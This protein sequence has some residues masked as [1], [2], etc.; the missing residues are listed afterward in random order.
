MPHQ[1]ADLSVSQLDTD[2]FQTRRQACNRIGRLTFQMPIEQLKVIRK[3]TVKIKIQRDRT[4]RRTDGADVSVKRSNGLNFARRENTDMSLMGLDPP[5]LVMPRT[6]L[7]D[8]PKKFRGGYTPFL[9]S[10]RKCRR[11]KRDELQREDVGYFVFL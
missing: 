2:A 5:A 1:H 10:I 8:D 3:R 7:S 11:R 9:Q 4:A 6:P